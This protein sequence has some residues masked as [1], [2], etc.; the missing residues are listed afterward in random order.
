MDREF[1]HPDLKN[2]PYCKV[3][4]E[5]VEDGEHKTE[6][7]KGFRNIQ[8]L[9]PDEHPDRLSVLY[10]EHQDWIPEDAEWLGDQPEGSDKAYESIFHEA[11][12]TSVEFEEEWD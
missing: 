10:S 3:V 9:Y 5:Y 4:I 6:I 8:Y 2:P 12:I 1:N 11:R 7:V